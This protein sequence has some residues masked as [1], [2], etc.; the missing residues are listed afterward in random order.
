MEDNSYS[1]SNQKFLQHYEL[2]A[3]LSLY[4]M[5][6]ANRVQILDEAVCISHCTNVLE[7]GKNS[8][9][10]FYN[11]TADWVLQPWLDN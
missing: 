3:Q 2:E 4:E 6:P 10:F 1:S 5:E 8:S 9:F 11:N 7:K